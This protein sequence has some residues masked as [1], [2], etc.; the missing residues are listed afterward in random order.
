MAI[1]MVGPGLAAVFRQL[2]DR[3]NPRR[4]VPVG[5]VVQWSLAERAGPSA[6]WSAFSRLDPRRRC[7]PGVVA[8][9]LVGLDLRDGDKALRQ[10]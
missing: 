9:R 6:A 10:G 3:W 5:R 7:A 2:F 8:L 1:M 4:W